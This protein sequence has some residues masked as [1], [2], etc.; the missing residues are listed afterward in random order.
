MIRFVY[1]L[2]SSKKGIHLEADFFLSKQL[3]KKEVFHLD[4]P[5]L[6][7]WP[8]REKNFGCF[9]NMMRYKLFSAFGFKQHEVI[10]FEDGGSVSHLMNLSI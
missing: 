8:K 3:L 7:F 5:G 4:F 1:N 9:G 10:I 6:V 2:L